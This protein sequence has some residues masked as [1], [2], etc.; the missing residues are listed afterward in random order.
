MFETIFDLLRDP[1]NFANWMALVE[2]VIALL[3]VAAGLVAIACVPAC[4]PWG[5]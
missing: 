3:M 4:G 2:C 1:S 5:C